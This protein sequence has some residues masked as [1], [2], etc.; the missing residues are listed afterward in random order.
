MVQHY[1]PSLVVASIVVAMLASYTALNFALRLR[2]ATGAVAWLWLLGGG[3]AMGTGI[4]SMHFVGMLALSLPMA[5]SYDGWITALSMLIA[6]VVSTFALRMASRERLSQA[7]LTGAGIAMGIGICA[8]H[9]VGMAAIRLQPP[10]TYEPLWVL[11][12][13]A[14][15]IAASFG[16]LGIVFSSRDENQWPRLTM[17]GVAMGFAIAGM[18]YAG[19][20]AAQFPP[21]ATSDGSALMATSRL[22]WLLTIVSSLILVSALLALIMDA[23]TTA[24]RLR[25]QAS[26]A[27]AQRESRARDEFLAMLGH[28]LRNPLASIFNAVFLLDRAQ[29]QTADWKYARDMIERQSLHLKRLLDDLLDVGRA[30]SGKM[31]L[32]LQPLDLDVVVKSALDMLASAGRTPGRRIDYRGASVWV[33]GDRT[34]LEQVVNNLVCNAV[35]H[36]PSDGSIELRL[37]EVSDM[38]RLTVRDYGAGLDAETAAR[39]FE[40]FYQARQAVQRPKGGMG[41]GLTLV[42]RIAEL[43]GG[44]ADVSS[45][46]RGK[47]ATFTV[48]LPAIEPPPVMP[49]LERRSDPR[50]RCAVLIVEDSEDARQSLRRLLELEGHR[51]H[52]AGDGA[53]GLAALLELQPD[54]AL[55]DIGLPALDGYDLA[56]QAR[57]AGVRTRLIAI[58]GYGL[59][60]DK[61]K[62]GAAGFDDHITKPASIEQ[63]LDLVSQ[64]GCASQSGPP[65]P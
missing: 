51:V 17:G 26:L 15:A 62:A 19:M 32:D 5:L 1:H 29:A 37:A 56:R 40:L 47:G 44:R 9:Y 65:K 55:I 6:V 20:A 25:I 48:T 18:H 52:S 28:E 53:S 7:R 35:D 8:M 13:F 22:A 49:Q 58:S 16:A 3:F 10:I 59:A 41:I 63:V 12:S 42:R 33:R 43:H 38:A 34:R 61:A 2:G 46:G 23:R 24:R 39:V 50:H 30:V 31:S 27:A 54:I 4:W 21:G 36:T 45:Q 14:I 64:A 57:A 11:A 60:E